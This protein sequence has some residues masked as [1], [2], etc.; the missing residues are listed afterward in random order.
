MTNRLI[1]LCAFVLCLMS[2]IGGAIDNEKAG[3]TIHSTVLIILS[4]A[5]VILVADRLGIEVF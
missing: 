1:M 2:G 3:R 4:V 5:V